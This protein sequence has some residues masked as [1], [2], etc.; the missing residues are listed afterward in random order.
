MTTLTQTPDRTIAPRPTGTDIGIPRPAPPPNAAF[1][2][3]TLE[4]LLRDGTKAGINVGRI[5]EDAA[6]L[7]LIDTLKRS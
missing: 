7:G 4:E 2:T 5:I 1:R 3:G 6:V